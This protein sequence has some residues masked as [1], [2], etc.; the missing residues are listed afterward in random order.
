MSELISEELETIPP[1]YK[2]DRNKLEITRVDCV[3]VTFEDF[4]ELA[5]TFFL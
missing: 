4:E 5:N 3:P 2:L 1:H